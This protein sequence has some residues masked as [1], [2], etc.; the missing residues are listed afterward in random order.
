[1]EPR[2]TRP[3]EY[4][5]GINP[6]TLSE[7]HLAVLA[8]GYARQLGQGRSLSE[9]DRETHRRL[10]AEQERRREEKRGAA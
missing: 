5:H 8:N 7:K 4:P 9:K 2:Y 6:A 10:I 3:A 1:M